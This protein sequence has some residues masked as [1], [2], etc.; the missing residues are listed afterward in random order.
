MIVGVPR[1]VKDNE[2]RVALTPEGAREFT[3]A[4]HRVLVQ[5]GA[6]AGSSLLEERYV[7]AGAEIVDSAEEVWRQAD[8]V[9]KVKEPV[10]SE[11]DLLQEGQVLFTFLHLAA[12][13]KLTEVL[14]ERKVNALAYET[15]QLDDGRLPLLA[16]MSEI[17]GRM[18]PHVGARLLEKEHGGRGILMGGVSGVRPAKVLVLG[19]GMAGSNAAWIA[20]GMEAEVMVV[21]KNLDKLRYI[22]QIHKGRIVT[23]MSDRLTLEQRVREADVVIGTVLVPGARAPKLVTEE[24]VASMRPGSVIIDVSIDQGG[25]VETSRMT[26][27]SDPTYVVHGVV[28]YCVGNMPGAVPNTSTYA[29]TNVTLPYVLAIAERGLEEALRSDPALVRG[30]NTYGGALTSRPVAEAHGLDHTPVSAV[31]PG[32]AGS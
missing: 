21:D 9:L 8:L 17:A 32:A 1:E 27:H 10:P 2:F 14:L 12:D 29:L 5:R 3:L 4:G 28:H 19:A 7:R 24:M 18:A 25:C 23:L 11:Y 13:R 6:G 16:P 15:V 30:L 26:T 31:V 22:D 20:A